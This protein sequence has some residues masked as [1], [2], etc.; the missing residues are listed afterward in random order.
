MKLEEHFF[1]TS[2]DADHEHLRVHVR[3]LLRAARPTV[4][5]LR[6]DAWRYFRPELDA[7]LLRHVEECVGPPDNLTPEPRDEHRQTHGRART[8]NTVRVK[9]WPKQ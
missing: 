4:A 2:R 5:P 9:Y 6:R 3:E 1:R 8:T 7:E